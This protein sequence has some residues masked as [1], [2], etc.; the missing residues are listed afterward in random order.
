MSIFECLKLAGLPEQCCVGNRWLVNWR[1]QARF[2]KAHCT[3]FQNGGLGPHFFGCR[4]RT[5]ILEEDICV[6][7]FVVLEAYCTIDTSCSRFCCCFGRSTMTQHCHQFLSFSS[8]HA[9]EASVLRFSVSSNTRKWMFREIDRRLSSR[10]HWAIHCQTVN[11][12]SLYCFRKLISGTFAVFWIQDCTNQ[13][14]MPSYL[15]I[16]LIFGMLANKY[17]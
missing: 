16:S 6:L 11:S 5:S 8:L 14:A 4:N 2:S 3:P 1:C 7:S 13:T 12:S 9:T 17:R 15:D 10:L